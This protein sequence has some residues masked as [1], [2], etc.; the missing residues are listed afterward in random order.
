MFL[1]SI[2]QNNITFWSFH[3]TSHCPLT[4]NV[5]VFLSDRAQIKLFVSF[6]VFSYYMYITFTAKCVFF[7][8]LLPFKVPKMEWKSFHSIY[9]IFLRTDFT[10]FPS[11]WTLSF[12]LHFKKQEVTKQSHLNIHLAAVL[13]RSI[14]VRAS[15]DAQLPSFLCNMS[16]CGEVRQCWRIC[17][18]HPPQHQLLSDKSLHKAFIFCQIGSISG[19]IY[20]L[21]SGQKSLSW[22]ETSLPDW[23]TDTSCVS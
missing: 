20:Y 3:T 7:F 16:L 18:L 15:E 19:I 14:A 23:K 10:D 6:T 21:I 22:S 1:K 11:Y 4:V 17:K 8:I 13:E 5:Q 2:W 12:I 9:T